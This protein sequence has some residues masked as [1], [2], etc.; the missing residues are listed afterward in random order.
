MIPKTI[1]LK[2]RRVCRQG[3]AWRHEAWC[4]WCERLHYHGAPAG[5]RGAHCCDLDGRSPVASYDLNVVAVASEDEKSTFPCAP[6]VGLRRFHRSIELSKGAFRRALL[7]TIFAASVRADNG[8]RKL[9]GTRINT[10]GDHWWIDRP[11]GQNVA[12]DD[13]LSLADALFAVPSGVASVRILEAAS[14]AQFDAQAALEIAGAVDAWK[15]RG[16]PKNAG[17]RP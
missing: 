4:P 13:L 10:L 12:G 9:Y 3:R 11:D 2:T 6:F 5:N 7:S 1:S 16:A 17:R 15:E 8:T 14:G